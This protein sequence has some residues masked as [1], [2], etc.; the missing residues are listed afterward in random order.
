MAFVLPAL[1]ICSVFMIRRKS[2]GL[3]LAPILLIKASTLL[4]SVGLGGLFRPLYGLSAAPGDTAFYLALSAV[5][6]GLAVLDL[7][8]MKFGE[9]NISK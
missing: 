4:L 3:I 9:E 8:K 6:L 5:Y 1:L 7:W 2:L